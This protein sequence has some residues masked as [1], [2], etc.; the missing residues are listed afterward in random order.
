MQKTARLL[1]KAD[2]KS[3]KEQ[4]SFQRRFK[5]S[6]QGGEGEVGN[7]VVSSR[8]KEREEA[9]RKNAAE[10]NTEMWERAR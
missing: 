1:T 10:V 9:G 8:E 7:L 2:F 3:R 5:E 4:C 6:S